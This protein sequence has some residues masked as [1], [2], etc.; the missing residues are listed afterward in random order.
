MGDFDYDESGDSTF[1]F[2]PA[3]DATPPPPV[4]MDGIVADVL[5]G[6]DPVL[7]DVDETVAWI[8]EDPARGWV[9]DAPAT[10]PVT[11]DLAPVLGDTGRLG[12]II[13]GTLDD[14]DAPLSQDEA[15]WLEREIRVNGSSTLWWDGLQDVRDLQQSALDDMRRQLE[16]K[17]LHDA[18]HG[19]YEAIND[20]NTQINSWPNVDGG[21]GPTYATP[22]TPDY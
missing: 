5:A 14:P 11:G 19:V 1:A 3:V 12:Q 7:D 9:G 18:I 8:A 16:Q 17:Q 22:P 10:D 13:S 15:A 20:P 4:P 6:T 2:A 21:S